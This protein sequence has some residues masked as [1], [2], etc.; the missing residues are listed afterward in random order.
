MLKALRFGGTFLAG[1]AVATCFHNG[2]FQLTKNLKAETVNTSEL[3]PYKPNVP[4]TFKDQ[5]MLPSRPGEIMK[6]GY[7]SLDNLRIFQNYVLS[8]DRRNRVANWVFEHL[9]YA[10]L[11]SAQD[12]DRGKSEFKE[13]MSIHPYFRS[14]NSDYKGSG[15][16]RGHLAAAANHRSSQMLMDETFYLSNMA[17]QVEHFSDK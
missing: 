3:V 17:P 14:T 16:D 7:P 8:Y 11:K 10:K 5:Q 4:A 13:D 9:T 1:V 15:Y 2:T 6:F 12:I